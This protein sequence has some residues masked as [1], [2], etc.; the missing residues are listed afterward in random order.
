MTNFSHNNYVNMNVT[1][2]EKFSIIEP[3]RQK[4]PKGLYV[5]PTVIS[6]FFFFFYDFSETNY[7]KIRWTDFRNLYVE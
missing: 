6:I 1:V 5:L 7:L 2:Y 4:L 3:A